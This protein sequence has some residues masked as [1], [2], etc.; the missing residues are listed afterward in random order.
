M[1]KAALYANTIRYLKTEQLWHQATKRLGRPCPLIKGYIPDFKVE[2]VRP[3]PAIREL[4]YDTE[5]LSRFSVDEL[6][7]NEV[8]LLHSSEHLDLQGTWFFE[9]RSPL[10]NHNLHYFEYL[11]ALTKQYEDSKEQ[12][13]LEKIK[14]YI[15]AWIKNN[16]QGSKNSA[17]ECYPIA[18]RLPNWIDL[19][20]L[21]EN[22]I[23]ADPEFQKV[24]FHYFFV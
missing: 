3:V 15:A 5:F 14:T 17:W 2:S 10:W 22:D 20:S 11:F 21:L 1:G 12:V 8:T 6:M 9:E 4:D 13:Y 19:Y 16:P 18:L 23:S 24:F 7:R